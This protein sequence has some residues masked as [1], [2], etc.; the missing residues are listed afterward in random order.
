MALDVPFDA[1]AGANWE[2]LELTQITPAFWCEL[3][4]WDNIDIMNLQAS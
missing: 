2:K 3:S 4:Q 1:S